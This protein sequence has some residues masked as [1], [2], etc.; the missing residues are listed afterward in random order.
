MAAYRIEQDTLLHGLPRF[1][2]GS[3]EPLIVL[4]GFGVNHANPKGMERPLELKIVRPLAERLRVHAVTRAPGMRPGT[5]MAEIAAQHAEALMAEFGEPVNVLGLSSGGSVALQL[6]ADHPHTVRKLVVAG[7]GH[8]LTD[9]TRQVQRRYTEVAA[10]G[11]RSLHL[12]APLM[13]GSRLGRLALTPGLWLMDPLMRA[14]D[15]ADPLAFAR[16]EDSFSIGDR[17]ADITAPALLINGEKDLAYTPEIFRETAE[18]IPDCRHIVYPG[19]S[20]M[21]SFTHPRFAADVADF[22][23]S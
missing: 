2:L 5:T 22:V 8:R 16:A 4:R 12:L 1:S 17:L 9:L 20:H 7:A 10:T 18:G 11:R 13:T 3:G 19:A 15:P 14:T 23:L 21:G 6:A